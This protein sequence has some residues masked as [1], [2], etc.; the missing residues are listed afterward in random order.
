MQD[1]QQANLQPE[2]MLA[3]LPEFMGKI[4]RL[5]E[6]LGLDLSACQ[7]DHIALRVNSRA[8]ATALHQAWLAY[9]EEWSTNVINGRPIVVIGFHQPLQA[10]QWQIEA[11]ELPYPGDKTYP[12]QG[13]E[14]VE[15]V[16]PCQASTTEE[17]QAALEARFPALNWERLDQAGIAVKASSP[18]GEKERLANPTFAFKKDGVCIKL[19]P[20]SL[21]AVIE[22]EG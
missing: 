13:W 15:F 9:G 20:C 21:K 3:Q 5:A 10:G 12:V 18:A 8:L 19:H 14:H 2:Q 4:E 1:L 11:L 22:S 17:L 16:V 6:E 7:A